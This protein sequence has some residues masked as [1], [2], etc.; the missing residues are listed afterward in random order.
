MVTSQSQQHRVHLIE[1]GQFHKEEIA[2]RTGERWL[3][4]YVH[5]GLAELRYS[6]IRVT[7]VF[8]LVVDEVDGEKTG[9]KVS[10][11]S[12]RPPV[13]LLKP[14]KRLKAGPVFSIFL[15]KESDRKPLEES[16]VLLQLGKKSY[17]LKVVASENGSGNCIQ[18][19]F[20]RNARLVL[21]S[22]NS[23]QTLYT[24]EDCGDIPSWNLLWAGDL[25]R[26]GKL[27][28]YMS[29]TQHYNT[30]ERRLFLSSHSGKGQLVKEVTAFVI[31]GC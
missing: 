13:F 28:L 7:R 27:D 4:L 14:S 22:G 15:D 5:K 21:V 10:V 6:K 17:V 25:D 18:S 12:S 1:T 2:A 23:S 31:S 11:A 8:D 3:A 9:K 16:P 29:V 24:L 20:P 19:V 30:S 26:D